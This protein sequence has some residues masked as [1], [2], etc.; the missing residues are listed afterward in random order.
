MDSVYSLTDQ[1]IHPF[2]GAPMPKQE[3]QRLMTWLLVGI[4]IIAVVIGIWYWMGS[5]SSQT[6]STA[7][8]DIRAQ[9]AGEPW[10]ARPSTLRRP[11]SAKSRLCS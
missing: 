9:V 1:T 2:S 6:T 5:R 8:Q 10:R 11:T 3:H 4:L 7:K